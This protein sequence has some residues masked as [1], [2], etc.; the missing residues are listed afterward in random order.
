MARACT[1]SD[2]FNAIA[3]PRRRDILDYL[4]P[5]ERPVGDIVLALGLGQ[6][7]VSKH[8]VTAGRCSIARTLRELNRFTNGAAD[9]NSTGANSSCESKNAPSGINAH[10]Q[11]LRGDQS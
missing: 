9:S 7:S 3:E 11:K 5:R 8:G 10:R 1:T 2:T 6:P 4:A